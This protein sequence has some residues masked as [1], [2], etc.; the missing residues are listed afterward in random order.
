MSVLY[1]NEPVV[2]TA[3][4][5]YPY[6]PNIGSNF[7]AQFVSD[8]MRVSASCGGREASRDYRGV[9]NHNAL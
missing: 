2:S 5:N 8:A 6:E 1:S 4:A 9:L 7:V 3:H